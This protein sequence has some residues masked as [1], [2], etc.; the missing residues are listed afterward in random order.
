[1]AT[2]TPVITR[3]SL[4]SVVFAYPA[5]A[6]G[7]DGDPISAVN[8]ADFSDRSVQVTGTF[9]S[10]GNLEVEGSNEVTP[11]NYAT[12]NNAQSGALDIT[13][14]GIKQIIEN[15]EAM[16]PR[17]TAGDGTT[18]LLVTFLLRRP[19]SGQESA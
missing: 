18:A 5:M 14:A 15:T 3:T 8:F 13:S 16:R 4:N 2:K 11:A 7:D 9:G 12:L 10:G 19:R 1:M 17:V 6:N